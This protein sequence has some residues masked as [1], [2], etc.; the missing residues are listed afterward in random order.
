MNIGKI[1]NWLKDPYN[2]IFLGILLFALFIRLYYFSLTKNQPLWWDEAD[3]LA[4]S[5]NLAGFKSDWIVT[6]QHNSLFP[7]IVA[8]LF[9]IGINEVVAK[10]IVELIP[11]ILIILLTYLVVSL[12]YHDKRIAL[13]SSFLMAVSWPILFNSMN[14]R[15]IFCFNGNVLF[16]ERL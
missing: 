14:T 15:I 12:M 5:K 6:K 9:S 11:S 4:Y 8:F 2:L 16:L 3:Y 7:F 1:K 10:F 13:I